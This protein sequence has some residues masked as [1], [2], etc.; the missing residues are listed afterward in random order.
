LIYAT[1]NVTVAQ[2]KTRKTKIRTSTEMISRH[3]GRRRPCR[4]V[5]VMF[6]SLL[7]CCVVS[8]LRCCVASSRR[9]VDFV[10]LCRR[11]SPWS[12]VWF[13]VAV[14]GWS[15]RC[16][17]ASLSLLLSLFLLVRRHDHEVVATL[18]KECMSTASSGD[19]DLHGDVHFPFYTPFRQNVGLQRGLSS[20]F[21]NGD[22]SLMK[23]DTS[24]YFCGSV[25]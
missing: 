1:Y 25:T 17:V 18:R 14:H 12:S 7:C 22:V 3:N 15:R 19:S 21:L 11:V 5:V 24:D 4:C 9:F 16:V 10:S 13:L 8:L 6:L 23:M 20:H 2:Y